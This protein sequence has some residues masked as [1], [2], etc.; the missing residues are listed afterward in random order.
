MVLFDYLCLTEAFYCSVLYCAL[1]NA[2][3]ISPQKVLHKSRAVD[4]VSCTGQKEATSYI[5]MR[6]KSMV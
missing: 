6:V 1:E 3:D 4:L 5:A 2:S